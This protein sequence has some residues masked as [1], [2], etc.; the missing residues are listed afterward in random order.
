MMKQGQLPSQSGTKTLHASLKPN[1][2]NWPQ[3]YNSTKAVTRKTNISKNLLRALGKLSD[4]MK[5][6]KHT[7]NKEY[8]KFACDSNAQSTPN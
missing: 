5:K 3:K 1:A 2:I 8:T 4:E 7:D 6:E